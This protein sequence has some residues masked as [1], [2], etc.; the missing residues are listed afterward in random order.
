MKRVV[1]N[2]EQY[3]ELCTAAPT[4]TWQDVKRLD[5]F[6]PNPTPIARAVWAAFSQY[7]WL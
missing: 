1:M 7:R 6:I 3:K 5:K 2:T 4:I